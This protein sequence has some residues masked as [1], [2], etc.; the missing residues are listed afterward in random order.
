MPFGDSFQS[1]FLLFFLGS[2]HADKESYHY[3]RFPNAESIK[4]DRKDLPS[5]P[6][7]HARIIVVSDTHN[8]HDRLGPFPECDLFVHCGDILMTGKKFSHQYQID[9]LRHFDEWMK[10]IPAERKVVI[11][12][13]HDEVFMKYT[14]QER[15]QLFS[16]VEYLENESIVWKGAHIWASPISNGKSPNRA[17]QSHAFEN[18]TLQNVPSSVD[19]LV[20]HGNSIKVSKSVDHKLH[21]FGHNHNSYGIYI[22]HEIDS[23]TKEKIAKKVGVCAP[24]C[25]GRYRLNQ[26]PII[27]DYPINSQTTQTSDVG[28]NIPNG[29]LAAERKDNSVAN[30][31]VSKRKTTSIHRSYFCWFYSNKKV[32]PESDN[33]SD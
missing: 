19:I 1:V 17:F 22:D 26:L 16:H 2:K 21:L 20:T 29:V 10:T 33:T 12:G 7:N 18:E 11:G 9:M 14:K 6:L 24:I 13:N 3:Y 8:R 32:S 31:I 4:V 25:D 15:K 5:V 30:S 27:I 23:L 28:T